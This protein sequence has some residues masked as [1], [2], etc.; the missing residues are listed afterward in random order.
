MTRRR[1]TLIAV[2]VLA[3][4]M[5]SGC[6]AGRNNVAHVAAPQHLAGFWLGLWQGFICPVTF[7]ISLF[8]DKV[9]V[10]EV[11]NNGNWYDFGF[12]LGISMIFG[13]S[14]GSNTARRRRST[15]R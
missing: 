11:H 10:Y 1:I 9:S 6:A 12:V 7:I 3:V 2:T 14:H 13:G 4:L 15:A 8:T 5:L